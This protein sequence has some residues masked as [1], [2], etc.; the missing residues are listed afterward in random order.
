MQVKLNCFRGDDRPGDVVD[1]PDGEAALLIEHGAAWL[2]DDAGGQED[3]VQTMSGS[4][5]LTAT[6]GTE[7]DTP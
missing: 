5:A 2:V 7:T 3:D 6:S 1:V 4:A